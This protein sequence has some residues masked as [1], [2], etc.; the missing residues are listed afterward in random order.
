M[1]RGLCHAPAVDQENHEEPHHS[2]P[3]VTVTAA[4]LRP[5]LLPVLASSIVLA[6]VPVLWLTLGEMRALVADALSEVASAWRSIVFSFAVVV[7]GALWVRALKTADVRTRGLRRSAVVAALAGVAGATA[8]VAVW[9]YTNTPVAPDGGGASGRSAAGRAAITVQSAALMAGLGGAAVTLWLNDRRR[10]HDQQVLAHERDRFEVDRTRF[11]DERSDAVERLEL[12]R[13][14]NTADRFARSIELLGH[15]EASV[16]VGGMHALAGLA[17]AR[18]ESTQT[19][20]DVL[21]AYL[22]QPFMHPDWH[23]APSLSHPSQAPVADGAVVGGADRELQVRRTATSLIRALLAA[24]NEDAY[25]VVD[26]TGA[27]LDDLDLSGKTL[28]AR[29]DRMHVFG[30]AQFWQTHFGAARMDGA[31]FHG[32]VNFFRAEFAGASFNGASFLS[33]RAQFARATFRQRAHFANSL[34]VALPNFDHTTFSK[35]LDLAG[36]H[37]HEG[38]DLHTSKFLVEQALAWKD[39]N[40]CRIFL[41]PEASSRGN[42]SPGRVGGGPAKT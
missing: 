36:A 35:G 40:I 21:C 16:R 22:R 39:A 27:N 25:Y 29:F 26:L 8:A 28:R 12:E 10:R 33:R 37:L 30:R 13:V 38:L 7:A 42:A 15:S 3:S 11:Q 19:V 32:Q 34:F 4:R 14:R 23:R 31:V 1:G 6:L 2:P 9:V 41:E 18:A 5:Y 17:R 20:I 24:N